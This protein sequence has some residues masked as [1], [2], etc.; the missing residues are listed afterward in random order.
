MK[1]F[2]KIKEIHSCSS[3]KPQTT[4]KILS[5]SMKQVPS[6][7]HPKF[8]MIK[9]IL[10][11][12][13][14]DKFRR[15]SIV[16]TYIYRI[17]IFIMTSWYATLSALV[18]LRGES[19]LVTSDFSKNRKCI[20]WMSS[21]LLTWANCWTN[22]RIAGEWSHYNAHVWSQFLGT[23]LYL[24]HTQSLHRLH[25]P[26]WDPTRTIYAMNCLYKHIKY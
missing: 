9:Y 20:V 16:L 11:R 14:T 7:S 19:P 18:V 25:G 5:H 13:L 12:T 22:M 2:K 8:Y 1:R 24:A 3:F 15:L 17:H 26:T 10:Y 21:L 23:Q 4:R 6:F